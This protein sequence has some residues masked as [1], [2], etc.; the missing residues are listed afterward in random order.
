MK[1]FFP[2]LFICLAVLVTLRGIMPQHSESLFPVSEYGKLPVLEGGRYK[3]IDSV[4]RTSLL[5]LGGKQSTKNLQGNKISATEWL[6]HLTLYPEQASGYPVFRIDHTDVKGLMENSDPQKKYFSYSDIIPHAHTI[7]EQLKHIPQEASKQDAAQ[8]EMLKL[9]NNLILYRRLSFAFR[10]PLMQS[11]VEGEYIRFMETLKE[12]SGI[13]NENPEGDPN[14]DVLQRVSSYARNFSSI[15]DPRAV[16]FVPTM[17]GTGA[18]MNL[19]EAMMNGVHA[20]EIPMVAIK[21]A[22][23]SDAYIVGDVLRFESILGELNARYET[24]AQDYPSSKVKAEWLVNSLQPFGLSMALYI[25][26][27]IGVFVAW[28]ILDER[29]LRL[30]FW[31]LLVAFV[32]HTTGMLARMIIQG[33]PPVTNLYSS[34]IFVG[35]GAVGL[36][37]LLERIFRNGIGGAVASIVGFMSLIIANH[38]MASGD[39]MEMMRAVLDSNFWLATHVITVSLGYSSTYLAGFLAFLYFVMGIFTLKLDRVTEQSLVRMVYGIVCFALLFSFIGTVLG[40][41]WAD[42]SWGRFWGWDP[43][44]NG[45]LM[46]VIWNALILHAKRSGMVRN[47]GFMNL[48][49]FGNVI[50]SWSWFGTNMLGVGLHSYGFMSSG[51]FWLISFCISQVLIMLLGGFI[52]KDKWRSQKSQN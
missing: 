4:A 16:K 22:Q 43:K 47:V 31:V 39:T 34:A 49:I 9:Y 20:G 1:K 41:I 18:W 3:P 35:W 8:R 25:L 14:S 10:V 51:F 37:L 27:M 36:G 2:I 28:L 50:T 21:Y 32:V 19:G 11:T 23:L 44:E 26:I 38:L 5:L 13:L 30:L 48:A 46:I 45:A 29:L 24:A 6:M 15:S 33:R 7:E 42:Q 40:G 52:P 17:P 12:A